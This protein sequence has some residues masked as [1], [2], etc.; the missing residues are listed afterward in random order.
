MNSSIQHYTP[1]E[2]RALC[3]NHAM[4]AKGNFE[5]EREIVLDRSNSVLDLRLKR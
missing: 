1:A 5:F 4:D 3:R 2:I